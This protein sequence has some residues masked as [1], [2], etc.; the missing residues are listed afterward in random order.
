MLTKMNDAPLDFLVHIPSNLA[1]VTSLAYIWSIN[2]LLKKKGRHEKK[3]HL[4]FELFLAF[5]C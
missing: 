4:S 5:T 3:C 1:C 2:L